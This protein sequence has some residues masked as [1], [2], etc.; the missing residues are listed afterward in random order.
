MASKPLNVFSSIAVPIGGALRGAPAL[1]GG[2]VAHDTVVDR[3][4]ASAIHWNVA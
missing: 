1:L 3:D 4:S 2:S